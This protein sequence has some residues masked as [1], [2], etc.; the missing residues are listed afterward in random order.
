MHVLFGATPSG[1]HVLPLI[2]LARAA[3]AAGHKVA[4]LSCAAL[5]PLLEPFDVLTAGPGLE[6]QMEET[7]RRTGL[8]PSQPGPAAV[9]HF[10]G[11]RVDLTYAEA[12]ARATAFRPDLIVTEPFDFVSPMLA[13]AL[14]VPWAA[15]GISGSVPAELMVSMYERWQAQLDRHALRATPRLAY[16]DPYPASLRQEGETFEADRIAVRPVPFDRDGDTFEI[17]KFEDE[18]RPRALL[19]L[20]N[21]VGDPH[22]EEGMSRSLVAAGFNVFVAGSQEPARFEQHVHRT[23]FVPLARI[24]PWADVV[25][26]AAGTGTMLAALSAGIPMVVRPFHADQPWNA[27]RLTRA[28]LAKAVDAFE[29]TGPAA[30]DIVSQPSFRR[31]A[32]QTAVEIAGM[33]SPAEILLTLERAVDERG[34]HEKTPVRWSPAR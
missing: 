29:D 34:D 17:P 14:D 5:A 1:G 33:A 20:G 28:G 13:A 23:G 25:V 19:T 30:L 24:L 7:Q 6:E 22:A 31:S 4:I 11:T 3:H 32:G 27:T 21:T 15:H 12:L 16:L 8:H 26:S 2:P 18:T 9:E 10:A